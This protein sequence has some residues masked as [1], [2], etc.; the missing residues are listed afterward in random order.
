[1]LPEAL[2]GLIALIPF[3]KNNPLSDFRN[4]L[5][6]VWSHL[7]LPSPTRRQ[8][9]IAYYLQYG[10]K[11]KCV[12]AFRGVGKSWITAAFVLFCLYNN[13]ALNILAVS[14]SKARADDFTTFCLRL[15]QEMPEL[16]HLRPREGQRSSKIAFDVGPAPA[17]QSPSLRSA[18]ITGQITGGRADLIV[19]DDIEIPNNSE[20]Q[21][22]R[23]KLAEQVKEFDAVLKPGGTI[24]YLGTPQTESSIYRLLAGRGYNIR[25]WPAR[26]PTNKQ[27]EEYGGTLHDGIAT[28]LELKPELVGKTTEPSRFSEEDLMERE[29]SYG[30]AGFALQFM[31]NTRLS[32]MDRYPLKLKDL[33]VMSTDAQMAPD[34]VVWAYD[35]RHVI[36]DLPVVGIDG[37][38]LLRPV[39]VGQAAVYRPYTG[40][41]MAI[42]PSGRGKDETGYAVVGICNGLLYLLDAGGFSDGYSDDTLKALA[43]LSKE[44]SVN[45]IVI[46][47]NF[48]DGMFSKILTPFVTKLRPVSIEEVKHSTQ[49]EKRIIDTLGPV[50][51]AHRLIVNR[52]L[53]EKDYR[54]TQDRG[55]DGAQRYQLFYQLTRITRDR[56]SLVQDDRLDALAI[57]VGYWVQHMAR[58]VDK[59]VE[60]QRDKD[61]DLLLK[62]FV[63]NVFKI[64]VSY[65]DGKN[66]RKGWLGKGLG[67]KRGN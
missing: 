5:K 23:E 36:N 41:V 4:F 19:P 64:G 31:L 13:P 39:D 8:L 42:D 54:S 63:R 58:D 34:R 65:S 60:E 6:L 40:I 51:S 59:A 1:L 37:D 29:L 38:K 10:P 56:G 25:V 44:W 17:S 21:L 45:K 28:D 9:E 55:T 18:G 32:D 15:I 12:Q 3:N 27:M 7:R 48:G 22:M 11:R 46:E 62:N 24:C 47:A 66:K 43:E 67:S 53:I 61:R 35:P 2:A 30:K 57:A 14:A 33:L 50:M 52:S 20:T 26:Y 16:A 49:K